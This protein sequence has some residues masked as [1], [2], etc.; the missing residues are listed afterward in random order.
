MMMLD[1]TRYGN[2]NNATS[3]TTGIKT[4][5]DGFRT[6]ARNQT[7]PQAAGKTAQGDHPR[8]AHAQEKEALSAQRVWAIAPRLG[9]FAIRERGRQRACSTYAVTRISRWHTRRFSTKSPARLRPSR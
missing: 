3:T 1:A 2:R 8:G 4:V 6:T 9:A 5:N 7:P